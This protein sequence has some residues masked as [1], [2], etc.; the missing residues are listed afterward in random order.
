MIPMIKILGVI[1]EDPFHYRTWSGSSS[2]FFHALKDNG[3]LYHAISAQPPSLSGWFSKLASFNLD[4]DKWRFKY[5]LN[6]R[7][8]GQMT[9][10]ALNKLSQ[11]DQHGYNVILQVGAWY[12]LTQRPD[13]VTVSYHDGNLHTRLANPFGHP[14]ISARFITAALNYEKRLYDNLDHIFTMSKWLA[15]SFV[16]DFEISPHKITPVGAGVNLPYIHDVKDRRYDQERILFVGCDFKRKGGP[17]LLEAFRI[18]RKEIKHATLR[19]IGPTL[20]DAPDGVTCF[21][22]V[23][24]AT[25]SGMELLLNEYS[26][27]SVFVMPS[28]Y[29]PFGIAFAE[30]MAHKLPCIG[31]NVCA[32]P[33]II[34]HGH[35]GYLVPPGDI[36]SLAYRITQL[37]GDPETCRAM[38][39]NAYLKYSDHYTWNRVAERII[40]RLQGG[41]SKQV[42]K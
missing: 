32:M 13:K 14:Q 38:G 11:L 29:E 5:H 8:F 39:E 10:T 22:F 15:D 35:T 37:L 16:R 31:T 26:S 33:E 4:I 25:R 40:D 24:K 34:D 20:S 42:A 18:V 27:A 30:A 41:T 23:S 6:T 28:L 36:K 9:E 7:Y 12:D 21:D 17:Q 2:H 19:I 3:V 1:D